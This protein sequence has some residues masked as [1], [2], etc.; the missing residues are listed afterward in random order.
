[1]FTPSDLFVDIDL[2]DPRRTARAVK[3][4]KT[5]EHCPEQPFPKI[6][7]TLELEGFY[8]FLRNPKAS[9]KKLFEHTAAQVVARCAPGVEYLVLHDTSTFTFNGRSGLGAVQPGTRGFLGHFSLLVEGA[10]GAPRGVVGA[11]LWQRVEETPS[12][13]R[14]RGA[15]E[16]EIKAIPSEM[17]RWTRAV[18]A[19][20]ARA[21]SANLPLIHVGD[22]EFDDFASLA[23]LLKSGS[24]FVVRCA[25]DRRILGDT[26][27]RLL[28]GRI[29]AGVALTTVNVSLS[30][31]G[32]KSGSSKRHPER[33]ARIA[34]LEVRSTQAKIRRPN[35]FP[36]SGGVPNFIELNIVR[37]YEHAPPDR[38]EAIDWIILTTEPV[39]TAPQAM[40]VLDIYKK[41][42]LIEEFFKALKTGCTYEARQL[43]SFET[44]TSALA[45]LAP[46]AVHILG[47]R[48]MA[49][50]APDS[51][52]TE[53]IAPELIQTL[54]AKSGK[55]CGTIGQ[56]MVEIAQLGGHLKSNGRPGYLVLWRGYREL[57][58]L[59]HGFQLAVK[60]LKLQT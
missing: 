20:E 41:R 37:A 29:Q 27:H 17:D 39:T 25:G 35:N 26:E 4:A 9:A 44:L 31:R 57:V 22:S 49:R 13:A 53:I 2:G 7:S 8:R 24:R 33:A 55:Q 11:E 18:D 19:V 48:A 38:E 50:T 56:A 16:A 40:R 51:A 47:L 52:A 46:I 36:S 34:T 28:T 15:S 43:E 45:F 59:T 14:K 58:I 1:M 6:F 30:Q 60:T 32:K 42:W 21:S 12:A 5:L 3:I 10:T 23:R 54:E